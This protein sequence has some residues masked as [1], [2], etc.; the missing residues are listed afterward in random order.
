MKKWTALLVAILL[1]MTNAAFAQSAQTPALGGR[2]LEEAYEALIVGSTTEMSGNFFTD[3]WGNNTS[4]I[5]VRKLLSA[6]SL[7]EWQATQGMFAVDQSVVGALTATMDATGNKVYTVALADDLKY[8][9]GSQITARDYVFSI[10]L[11]ASPVV[12]ELGGVTGASDYILGASAYQAGTTE[13]LSGVRLLGAYQFSVTVRSEMLPFFYELGLLNFAPYPISVIAPGSEVADDGQGA[14]IRNIDRT[15]AQPL[16]TAELLTETVFNEATGYMSHP[17]VTS[18]PYRLTGYDAGAKVAT[19]EIN[20]HF[21][22][23]SDGQKPQIKRLTYRHVKPDEAANLLMAGEVDLLNKCTQASVIDQLMTQTAAGSALNSNYSRVGLTMVSF[24][25][26]QGAGQS[27]AVRQALTYC[28]DRIAFQ[29]AYTKNYGLS[30]NGYYGMGQWMVQLVNGTLTPPAKEPAEGEAA[31]GEAAEGAVDPDQ[32]AWDALSLDGLNPYALDEAAAKA[33]LAGDGWTLN[34][35]G[36]AYDEAV[37]G[38]RYKETDQGLVGLALK[39][40]VPAGNQ[41]AAL[42]EEYW[43]AHLRNVG[44]ELTVEEK[45]LSEL[46]KEYYRQSERTCDLYY[47]GTNFTSVFDPSYTYSLADE[48]QGVLN[49]T[50][51]K[52]Q[53]LYDLAL[54]MHKTEQGDLLGY[55]QNWAE[56]QTRWNEVLP[57]IPVYS[58]VYFDF[59]V[60]RLQNYYVNAY[61]TW[62]QAVVYAYLSDAAPETGTDTVGDLILEP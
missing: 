41:A 4:D 5:D 7:V 54:Q 56:F 1:L 22:G 31:A 32:A 24:D 8:S 58:N 34:A 6:Y 40:A 23:T 17:A 51:I 15:A 26:S 42:F 9:D 13:V 18:G 27:Q 61:S 11:S 29:S 48:H 43:V 16:F 47:L 3:M 10:L 45:A 2:T 21:N 44:V 55:C 62:T 52:D 53:E 25:C 39:L 12:K 35:E 57:S 59:Y 49:T 37:G 46:L 36:S 19:F 30:V 20:E 60:P 28:F 33:L 14:Y 38:V 50:G